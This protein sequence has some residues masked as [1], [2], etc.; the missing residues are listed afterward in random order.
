MNVLQRLS[1]KLRNFLPFYVYFLLRLPWLV[2]VAPLS[3][4]GRDI[5][6]VAARKMGFDLRFVGVRTADQY[7]IES[8]SASSLPG[9]AFVEDL[10]Y[11]NG[12]EASV[13]TFELMILNSLVRFHKPELIVEFGTFI[14]RTALNFAANASSARVITIDFAQ[15]PHLFDNTPLAANIVC[16]TGD[17]TKFVVGPYEGRAGFIFIDGGHDKPIVLSDSLKAMQMLTP[18]GIIVWH[19]YRDF[20]GV[21]EA[22]DLLIETYGT[23]NFRY[24]SDT[25]MVVYR[26]AGFQDATLS[27]ASPSITA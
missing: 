10:H 12:D 22:I 19:D 2:L 27:A 11:P 9:V 3:F 20:R 23:E 5:I 14:G 16:E 8:L 6:R 26:R 18:T 25:S 13:S 7:P 15:Q 24:V 21:Q 17:S 1:A 4:Y